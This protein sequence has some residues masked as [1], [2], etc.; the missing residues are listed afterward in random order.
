MTRLRNNELIEIN[1]DV[2]MYLFVSSQMACHPCGV[3]QKG[4]GAD[5]V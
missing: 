1:K 4:H 3:Y 5:G 2:S